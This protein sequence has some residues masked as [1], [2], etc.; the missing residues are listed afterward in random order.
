MPFA[1][2]RKMENNFITEPHLLQD[3]K[4]FMKMISQS[5]THFHPVVAVLKFKL[6]DNMDLVGKEPELMPQDP[7]DKS[8]A[9]IQF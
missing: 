9:N 4:I 8:S 5:L 3:G 6:L 1:T 7:L 2:A